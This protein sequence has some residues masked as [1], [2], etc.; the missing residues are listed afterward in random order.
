MPSTN[1]LGNVGPVQPS[2]GKGKAGMGQHSSTHMGS[3]RNNQVA[4]NK[5]RLS[6]NDPG[7]CMDDSEGESSDE[8]KLREEPPDMR[9]YPEFL[10]NL[11]GVQASDSMGYR[12]EALRV[13]LEG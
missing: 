9:V 3:N 13:Y 8:D 2:A 11:P 1:S 10:K 7:D 5:S 12:I 4:Q 6:N